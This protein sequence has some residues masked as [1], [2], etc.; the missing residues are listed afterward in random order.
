MRLRHLTVLVVPTLRRLPS[1]SEILDSSGNLIAYYYPNHI[2]RVPVSYNQIS[3]YMRDAIV[4]IED[5][6]LPARRDRYARSLRAIGLDFARRRGPGRI[7]AGAA[8]CQERAGADRAECA[9][10][11]RGDRPTASPARSASCGSRRQSNIELTQNQLLAAYLNVAYFE[12][13]AYGIQVA[14]QRYFSTTAAAPD[15]PQ[16]AMLAGLVQNP[17]QYDPLANP[18]A[19]LSRRNVVLARMA[20]LHYVSKAAAAAAEQAP[21]GLHYSAAVAAEGCNST[22]GQELGLVLRL[23]ARRVA[24]QPCSTAR[25][26]SSSTP[27]AG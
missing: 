19:A 15:A 7:H 6:R 13:E 14:A 11:A 1:R 26:T 22:I 21:L 18:R 16:S 24:G 4:A 12:N 3:P 9:A 8:V 20:Q 25:P 2:Y 17:A 23:R 27:S 10:A 5:S